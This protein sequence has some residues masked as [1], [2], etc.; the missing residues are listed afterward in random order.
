LVAFLAALA[1][2][3]LGYAA[4]FRDSSPDQASVLTAQFV[5]NVICALCLGSLISLLAF[6]GLGFVYD[7]ELNRLHVEARSLVTKLLE[8]RFGEPHA[9]SRNGHFKEQGVIA[10]RSELSV[11]ARESGNLPRAPGSR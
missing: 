5:M 6:T 10:L 3:G 2:A 1:V 11:S 8:C 7:R 4:V 9:A